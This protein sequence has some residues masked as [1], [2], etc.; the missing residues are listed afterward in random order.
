MNSGK[1]LKKAVSCAPRGRRAMWMLNIQV[2]TQSISPLLWSIETGSLEAAKAIIIDLLT[3]RAD[4]DQYYYGMAD[5]F[6]RHEDIIKRLCADAPALLPILLD[7]LM[8]RSR[9]TE[10]GQRRVNYY[11]KYLIIDHDGNFSKALEW[12]TDSKD[13]K[14]IC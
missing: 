6:D 11:L 8:W 10:N 12:I 3:I 4:R 9:L 1:L 7:G 5:L 14:I 13:P 2:G